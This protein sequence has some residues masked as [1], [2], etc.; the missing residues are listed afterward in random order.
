MGKSRPR[1][2]VDDAD[3]SRFPERFGRPSR[4][5]GDVGDWGA[6]DCLRGD[7]TIEEMEP[8]ADLGRPVHAARRPGVAAAMTHM[9][10][11]DRRFGVPSIRTDVPARHGQSVASITDF[12]LGTGAGQL[13]QPSPYAERGVDESDFA[14]ARRPGELRD[15]F[16]RA[17]HTLPDAEF[18][19]IYARVRDVMWSG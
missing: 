1:C 13:L 18:A 16:T 7:Y 5:N 19:A 11:P 3:R 8:D 10:H 15:I 12:G 17:G 9:P 14:A 2:L 4:R 6:A